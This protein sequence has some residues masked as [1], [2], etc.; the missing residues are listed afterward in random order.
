MAQ[1]GSCSSSYHV[2]S[3]EEGR[4]V[5]EKFRLLFFLEDTYPNPT[6]FSIPELKS[7]TSKEM[8]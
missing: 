4:K 5:E 6:E 1:E 2:P 7:Q 8:E 3:Q